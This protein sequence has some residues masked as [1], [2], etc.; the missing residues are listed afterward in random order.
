VDLTGLLKTL[1]RSGCWDRAL[2]VFEWARMNQLRID[3]STV[4]T[5]VHP[6]GREPK[7]LVMCKVL[8][9]IPLQY[10]LV[11]IRAYTEFAFSDVTQFLCLF[12]Q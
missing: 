8:D 3:T 6:L 9:K 5:M 11:D 4:E 12:V 7:Y 1:V 2:I 10:Y